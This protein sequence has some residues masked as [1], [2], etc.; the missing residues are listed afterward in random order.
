MQGFMVYIFYAVWAQMLHDV[1]NG[2]ASSPRRQPQGS[3]RNGEDGD[4]KGFGQVPGKLRDRGELFRGTRLQ[5]HG[6][7]VLWTCTGQSTCILGMLTRLLGML[8]RLMG[9][10]THLLG[11][12]TRS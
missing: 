12:L 1:D 9:M 3:S 8:T 10:L 4:H 11:G 2:A 5:V 7:H 6:P